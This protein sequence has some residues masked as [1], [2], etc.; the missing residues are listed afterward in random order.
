MSLSIYESS[1][2][3]FARGLAIA[4][5]LLDK[6]VAHAQENGAD[7]A[8]YV[9][10][11]LAP[12]M[13]NLAGQIQRASDTAKFAAA[14]LTGTEAPAFPDEEKSIDELKVRCTK[15]NAY[16][17]QFSPAQFEGSEQR[18]VTFGGGA[19]KRTLAGNRYLLSFALPNFF[20]HVTTAY[21]ILRHLGVPVG[22]RDYLGSFETH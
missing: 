2:P 3:V 16:L 15:T 21:D 10:A 4:S 18:M 22:K 1:V 17:E 11:R 20:F 5:S 8:S 6:A 12:D 13:L 19:N 7:P 9:E 14:R